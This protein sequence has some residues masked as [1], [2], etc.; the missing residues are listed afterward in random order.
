[1]K[2]Q[3]KRLRADIP[4][5][6][7]KTSGAAAFDIATAEEATIAPGEIKLL[8][9]GLVI[10]TPPGHTLM[11]TSRSSAGIKFGLMVILGIVDSDYCGPEDELKVQ[12]YNFIKTPAVLPKGTRI[13]QGLFVKIEK[14]EWEEVEKLSSPTRGGFGATGN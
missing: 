7:Y 2:I 10:C 1:M 9:T 6:E 13:A 12:A 11:L 8:R 3:I 14:G 5:P 4:L